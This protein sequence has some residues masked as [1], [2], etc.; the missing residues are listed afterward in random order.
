VKPGVM[1]KP[2]GGRTTSSV[3]RECVRRKVCVCVCEMAVVLEELMARWNDGH[4]TSWEDATVHMVD[5]RNINSALLRVVDSAIPSHEL[6]HCDASRRYFDRT[7]SRKWDIVEDI[8]TGSPGAKL[9]VVVGGHEMPCE[10]AVA[11]LAALQYSEK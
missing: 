1:W 8:H 4:A 10:G 11:P 5:N 2:R 3:K 9:S 7:L 6:I